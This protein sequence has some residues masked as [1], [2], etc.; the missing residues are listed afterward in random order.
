MRSSTIHIGE[1]TI[2]VEEVDHEVKTGSL[3]IGT[4]TRLKIKG[5]NFESE[6]DVTTASF[7]HTYDPSEEG[8]SYLPHN[9]IEVMNVLMTECL[10]EGSKT[11]KWLT[12][13]QSKS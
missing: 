3:V 10:K 7:N 6:F 4:D 11:G 8:V 13:T 12:F 5:K 1:L 9:L 2:T